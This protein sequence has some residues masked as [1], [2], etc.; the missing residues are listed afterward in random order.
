MNI[1]N[2]EKDLTTR[3]KDSMGK[4]R[5]HSLFWE[6]KS[7]KTAHLP[8]VFTLKDNDHTFNE[9]TY[10]SMRRLY[11]EVGDPSEY[12]FAME[13]LG[14]WAHWKRLVNNKILRPY[15][16]AWREELELKL[17]SEA[18][19]AVRTI[20][21]DKSSKGRLSAAKWIADRGWE[22]TR[23]R[24][25]KDEVT[26]ERKIVAGIHDELDEDYDRLFGTN[27]IQ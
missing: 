21:N 4:F 19:L 1:K 22:K 20:S 6:Y 8:P 24:P 12:N 25:T 18:V 13:V 14:S 5:T 27:S 23:G 15:I 7:K 26:R 11:L 16:D 17:R 3:Y 10:I 9:N 2:K